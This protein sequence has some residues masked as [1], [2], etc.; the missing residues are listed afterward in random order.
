MV[1]CRPDCFQSQEKLD[2]EVQFQEGTGKGDCQAY[3]IFEFFLH[4]RNLKPRNLTL[5]DGWMTNINRCAAKYL[6]QQLL[7]DIAGSCPV[8]I[9]CV[10]C[11]IF[12]WLIVI[13][14]FPQS[15]SRAHSFCIFNKVPFC[16][17]FRN[18]DIVYITYSSIKCKVIQGV[19]FNWASPEFAK[20]W[21]VSN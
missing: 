4:N 16:N 6:L 10:F 19:F 5:E 1:I 17:A 15:Y 20:C 11:I 14:L 9:L 3:L 13:V 12:Y 8:S 7:G 21:P 18:H 2:Q